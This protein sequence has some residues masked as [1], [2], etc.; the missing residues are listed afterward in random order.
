VNS[1]NEPWIATSIIMTLA[2]GGR[3]QS[4]DDLLLSTKAGQGPLAAALSELR[5]D[6]FVTQDDHGDWRLSARGLDLVERSRPRDG[7][8][9]R[10]AA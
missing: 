10:R 9:A 5:G 6:L 4:F 8:Q 7:R 3:P 2:S 1:N